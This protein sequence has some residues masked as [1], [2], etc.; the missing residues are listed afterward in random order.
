M[1]EMPFKF[2]K[3]IFCLFLLLP[4]FSNGQLWQKTFG[5]NEFGRAYCLN[6]TNDGGYLI[7]GTTTEIGAGYF[8]AFALKID[9]N[10]DTVWARSFGTDSADFGA[11]AIQTSDGG[12]LI[13]GSTE[14][15]SLEDI[16]VIKTDS[17][18]NILWAKSFGGPATDYASDVI[19][20]VNG[21]VIGAV[22]ESFG[23]G[24]RDFYIIKTNF[25]G[26]TLWT[27]VFGGLSTDEC[28][29][30]CSTGD[31]GCIAAGRTDNFGAGA[32]D[33]LVIRL[34]SNGAIVWSKTYGGNSA[35]VCH[36][37]R[38]T[39]NGGYILSGFTSSF[40]VFWQDA[41]VVKIDSVGN[42]Q[43]SR[44]FGQTY[45]DAAEDAIQT[46]DSGYIVAGYYAPQIGEGDLLLI[47]MNS[48]G[49]TIW[50][51]SYGTIYDEGALA[52][53]E[54]PDNG[55]LT[56]GTH[57]ISSLHENI[58]MIKTDNLGN[59][60]CNESLSNLSTISPATVTLNAPFQISSGAFIS[61]PLVETHSGG[62]VNTFCFTLGENTMEFSTLLS[63]YPNPATNQINISLDQYLITKVDLFSI[64]GD[65]VF[66]KRVNSS[67]CK[68]EVDLESGFY[69]LNA[70]STHGV[71][72]QKVLIE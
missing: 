70:H 54:T 35:D 55:F 23:A 24:L 32:T 20:T 64:I 58:Y 12:Y 8:D 43:W 30:I 3:R 31:G 47:R 61:I 68:I 10:G 44:I 2:W 1:L 38:P 57:F 4:F 37:I 52:I 67:D 7:A 5:Q 59:S 25:L 72:S 6:P 63:V 56:I 69:I 21:Y 45:F 49:D 9:L 41:Y 60:G 11:A 50:S 17:S 14:Q 28:Y 46:Q 71:H 15:D 53:R 29:S 18:G 40:G 65:Q 27:R 39:F 16:Y 48:V 34:D 51:R 22:T 66:S 33:V 42:V 26:D 62:I 36:R 19:E 13:S